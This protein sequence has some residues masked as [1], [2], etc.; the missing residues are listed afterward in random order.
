MKESIRDNLKMIEDNLDKFNDHALRFIDKKEIRKYISIWRWYV[1]HDYF[2]EKH[3]QPEGIHSK[4]PIGWLDAQLK[5]LTVPLARDIGR[6]MEPVPNSL[7]MTEHAAHRIRNALTGIYRYISPEDMQKNAERKYKEK[8]LDKLD[9]KKHAE[10]EKARR[11]KLAAEKNKKTPE[12]I[13]KIADA[14]LKEKEK[15]RKALAERR[16][17]DRAESLKKYDE[18]TR[19]LKRGGN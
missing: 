2:N 4:P 7:I 10:Y 11:D 14:Y 19:R 15:Q 17:R 6:C 3:P 5:G 8:V 9:A 18:E 16:E 12:Q 1:S 13:Q